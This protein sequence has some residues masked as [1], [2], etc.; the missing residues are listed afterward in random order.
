MAAVPEIEQSWRLVN[1]DRQ[2]SVEPLFTPLR[3][4]PD[5]E[6]TIPLTKP[7]ELS[8][9]ILEKRSDVGQAHLEYLREYR[10][11]SDWGSEPTRKY[12]S[13]HNSSAHSAC[14]SFDRVPAEIMNYI[15]DFLA[16]DPP[17]QANQT[18]LAF[19][20]TCQPAWQIVKPMLIARV[21]GSDIR[22]GDRLMFVGDYS[23]DPVPPGFQPLIAREPSEIESIVTRKKPDEESKNNVRCKARTLYR[24][25][26]SEFTHIQP[27]LHLQP[28]NISIFLEIDKLRASHRISL[29]TFQQ[30][31]AIAYLTW[32]MLFPQ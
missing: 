12:G 15:I 32:P 29:Q 16:Q 5:V 6:L 7:R 17:R 31:L 22:R 14:S 21:R 20:L 4:C 24:W 13:S 3:R 28:M 27:I 26:E 23:P 25:A 1:F 2:E 8:N 10:F 30:M 19:G 18:H 9:E 11:S